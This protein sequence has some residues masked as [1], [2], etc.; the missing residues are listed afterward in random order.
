MA[1]THEVP[2]QIHAVIEAT[3]RRTG[4]SGLRSGSEWPA[5]QERH[6]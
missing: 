3:E 4:T 2:L 1:R 5:A 6:E